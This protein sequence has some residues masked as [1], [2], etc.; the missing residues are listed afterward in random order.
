MQLQLPTAICKLP[1]QPL[2]WLSV[3]LSPVLR[4]FHVP[5]ARWACLCVRAC[6]SV[7][8]GALG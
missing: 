8:E 3:L 6:A 4:P 5:E 1:T 7:G 2:E